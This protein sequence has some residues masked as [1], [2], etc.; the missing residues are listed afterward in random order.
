V[1]EALVVLDDESFELVI[2]DQRLPKM[3]GLSC[4]EMLRA[5]CPH[6]TLVML[7]GH[8]DIALAVAA[9]KRGVDH[10]FTKPIVVDTFLSEIRKSAD[11]DRSANVSAAGR[12]LNLEQVERDT[13]ASAMARSGG[14]ITQAA[15]LLGIDRRTL[16]RKLRRID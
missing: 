2:L 16:Q 5:R 3:D 11:T 6:G 9:T 12:S 4:V 1:E 7:T 15:K 8:G 13:I 14:V 10:F